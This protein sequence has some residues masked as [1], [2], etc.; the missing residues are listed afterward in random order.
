MKITH[1]VV[2]AIMIMEITLM[3]ITEIMVTITVKML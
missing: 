1:M 2:T 3:V